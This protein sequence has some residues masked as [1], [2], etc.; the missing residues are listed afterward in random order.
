MELLGRIEELFPYGHIVIALICVYVILHGKCSLM[1]DWFFSSYQT[2]KSIKC[3][4]WLTISWSWFSQNF[5]YLF[6]KT[7]THMKI[8]LCRIMV[9]FL[10]GIKIVVSC[11]KTSLYTFLYTFW[12][13]E[14]IAQ[15]LLGDY[16]CLLQTSNCHRSIECLY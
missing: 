10:I 3:N 14:N 15:G 2:S 13:I 8:S 11:V 4:H 9:L 16:V 7:A 5:D 1:R 6:E 12:N